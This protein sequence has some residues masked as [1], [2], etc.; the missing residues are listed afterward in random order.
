MLHR[1]DGSIGTCL[2]LSKRGCRRCLKTAVQNEEMSTALRSAAFALEMVAAETRG[3]VAAQ[4]VTGKLFRGLVTTTL[5]KC[6]ACKQHTQLRCRE[7]PPE[8]LTA[9]DDPRHTLQE[10]EALRTSGTLMTVTFSAIRSWCRLTFMNFGANDKSW[11][12]AKSAENRG[13]LLHRGPGRSPT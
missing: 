8:N 11:S 5:Q 2:T 12:R 7:S 13:D 10:T 6:S 9:A 3:R 1:R 4:Q